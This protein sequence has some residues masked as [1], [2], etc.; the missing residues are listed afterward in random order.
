[1]KP[2]LAPN[3]ESRF[4]VSKQLLMF[5]VL[6]AHI[7][8]DIVIGGIGSWV[9]QF[10]ITGHVSTVTLI[11]TYQCNNHAQQ[12]HL[13]LAVLHEIHQELGARHNLELLLYLSGN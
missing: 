7:P 12:N 9:Q 4:E 2:T 1:M 5:G 10:S 6:Q 13:Y 11:A 8:Y 3:P